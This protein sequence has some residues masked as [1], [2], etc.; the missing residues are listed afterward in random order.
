MKDTSDAIAVRFQDMIMRRNPAERLLMGC[1]MYDT[2]KQIVKSSIL[3]QNQ[4][5]TPQKLKEEIFLRFYG[6]EFSESEK[7]KILSALR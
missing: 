4:G 3:N 1:S 6:M 7:K 5:I 2:A